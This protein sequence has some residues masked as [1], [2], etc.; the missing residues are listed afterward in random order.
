FLLELTEKREAIDEVLR[1]YL[2]RVIKTIKIVGHDLDGLDVKGLMIYLKNALDPEDVDKV[3]SSIIFYILGLIEGIQMF[4]PDWRMSDD[5]EK[6]ENP[7]LTIRGNKLYS[8]EPHKDTDLIDVFDLV[9]TY[10]QKG[11]DEVAYEGLGDMNNIQKY[12]LK[13][14]LE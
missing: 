8:L 7:S 9:Y 13:G 10:L 5:E 11:L 12:T 6:I 4:A 3:L 2:I 1:E 14:G